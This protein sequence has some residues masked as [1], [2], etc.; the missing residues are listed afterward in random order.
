[1]KAM[2]LA[3]GLGVRLRPITDDRPKALVEI[4]GRTL[5]EITLSRLRAL[6]IRDVIINVHSFADRIVGYLENNRNFGMNIAISRE[7]ILLDTGGG[8]KKAAHFF[9]GDSGSRIEPFLLHNVDVIS[10]IDLERMLRFHGESRA[11]ATL[12]VQN[13]QTNRYLLFDKRLQ[14]CGRRSGDGQKTEMAR[15]AEEPLA[16]AFS[17]IH[18]I[19]PRLL[20]Q[21]SEEG[22]FS[23]ITTYLRLAA[24]GERI[25]AFRADDYYWRDVGRPED[26]ALAAQEMKQQVFR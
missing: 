13:R 21:M 1:M 8:L 5:L 12:A 24:A 18:V 26:L 11:L 16:L 20:E 7:E 17:G 3:A 15:P 22:A 19:S 23:I 14:L 25:Q 9:L 10:T 6:G 4:G 2:I